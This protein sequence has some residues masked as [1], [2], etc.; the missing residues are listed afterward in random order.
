MDIPRKRNIS[1]IRHRRI[2]WLPVQIQPI[3]NVV[4]RAPSQQS[5]AVV[6]T[7]AVKLVLIGHFN[8]SRVIVTWLR[9]PTNSMAS[10]SA[11]GVW[12]G[13]V[14]WNYQLFDCVLDG[15]TGDDDATV[16]KNDGRDCWQ[17]ERMPAHRESN[18]VR[19]WY[20]VSVI[21]GLSGGIVTVWNKDDKWRIKVSDYRY[22]LAKD[23]TYYVQA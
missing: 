10:E 16:Y 11:L 7:W 3:V 20:W 19:L 6:T 5:Y 15:N 2:C 14:I 1:T 4:R 23:I 21:D 12:T 8:G 17:D 22:V 13:A 9:H 18:R